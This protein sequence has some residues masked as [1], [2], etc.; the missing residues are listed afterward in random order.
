MNLHAFSKNKLLFFVVVVFFFLFCFCFLFCFFIYLFTY[1][2]RLE[3]VD[4]WQSQ[5]V[6]I[7]FGTANVI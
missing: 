5:I 4:I 1:L 6:I 3:I 7:Y 2:L